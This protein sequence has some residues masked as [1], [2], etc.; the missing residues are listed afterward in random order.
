M[1]DLFPS[2][3]HWGDLPHHEI[4]QNVSLVYQLSACCPSEGLA[5]LLAYS[6]LYKPKI[7][8]Q[9]SDLGYLHSI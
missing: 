4:Y 8:L 7:Q 2:G 9:L 5:S 3:I 6:Q 1:G